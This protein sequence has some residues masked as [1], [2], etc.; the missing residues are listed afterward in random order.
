MVSEMFAASTQDRFRFVPATSTSIETSH[1]VTVVR[2]LQRGFA[3]LRKE[4]VAR[5]APTDL[6][7]AVLGAITKDMAHIECS[8][9]DYNRATLFARSRKCTSI[10]GMSPR[11]SGLPEDMESF[12]IRHSEAP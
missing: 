11:D 2:T 6:L 3:Q 1:F 9:K 10:R 8:L 4:A 7:H 12:G 5:S